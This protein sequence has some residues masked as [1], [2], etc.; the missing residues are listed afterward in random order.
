MAMGSVPGSPSFSDSSGGSDLMAL[1]DQELENDVVEAGEQDSTPSAT[2]MC[3]EKYFMQLD[4][5]RTSHTEQVTSCRC[6]ES[7]RCTDDRQNKRQR[8]GMAFLI[9]RDACAQR[10]PVS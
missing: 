2:E 8:L 1:L 10:R 7:E 5:F 6:P 4:T 3:A 9:R